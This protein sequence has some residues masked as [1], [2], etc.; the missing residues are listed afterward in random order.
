VS[1]IA[2]RHRDITILTFF[3]RNREHGCLCLLS[4]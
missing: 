1:A 3:F 2:N 4:S